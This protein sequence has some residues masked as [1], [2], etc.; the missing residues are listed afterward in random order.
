MKTAL[1]LALKLLIGTAVAGLVMTA[2]V[3]RA[4]AY[5]D[6][7]W[8]INVGN[9]VSGGIYGYPAVAY[10]APVVVHPRPVYVASPAPIYYAPPRYYEHNHHSYAKHGQGYG[11]GKKHHRHWKHDH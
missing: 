1:K 9:A 6:V 10:P 7:T 2:S 4:Q 3:A 8:S 11:H 5:P